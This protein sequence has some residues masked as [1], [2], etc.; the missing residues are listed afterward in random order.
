MKI[1]AASGGYWLDRLFKPSMW[2]MNRLRYARKFVLIG[3]VFVIP[4]MVLTFQMFYN[5]NKDVRNTELEARG[6][7]ISV[8]LG[9]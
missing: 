8:A 3:L 5:M 9:K 6:W 4:I 7:F 1:A 2:L